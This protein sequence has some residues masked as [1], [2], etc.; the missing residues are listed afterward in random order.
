MSQDAYNARQENP[1]N[2]G[3]SAE[4]ISWLLEKLAVWTWCLVYQRLT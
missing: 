1:I 2:S 3:V 4:K